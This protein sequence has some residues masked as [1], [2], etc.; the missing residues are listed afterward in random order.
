MWLCKLE[1][2]H[3]EQFSKFSHFHTHTPITL[4]LMLQTRDIMLLA[5]HI[6]PSFHPPSFS[7]HEAITRTIAICRFEEGVR[8]PYSK[9][10]KYKRCFVGITRQ[11][12][13]IFF[14]E[15]G[16]STLFGM[17]LSTGDWQSRRVM[18]KFLKE[19]RSG[20]LL[21]SASSQQS[22]KCT[23]YFLYF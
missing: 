10:G 13:T 8:I 14:L 3:T 17:D 7:H 16:K 20:K 2:S 6:N 23:M 1:M 9:R 4:Y 12:D 18:I 5:R 21:E 22:G 11:R 19:V 15:W